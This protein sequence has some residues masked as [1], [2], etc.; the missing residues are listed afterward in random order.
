MRIFLKLYFQVSGNNQYIYLKN[1][2]VQLCA[3]RERSK[4][5]FELLKCLGIHSC[6]IDGFCAKSENSD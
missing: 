6:D 4:L 1:N 5:H 2:N 3:V